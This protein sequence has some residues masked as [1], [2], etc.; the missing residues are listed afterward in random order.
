MSDEKDLIKDAGAELTKPLMDELSSRLKLPFFGAFIFSWLVIN[1]ERVAI[2][3]LSKENVYTRIAKIKEI[4]QIELPVIGNWHSSTFIAPLLYSMLVTAITPFMI[5]AYKKIQKWANKRIIDTQAELDHRYQVS[6]SLEQLKLEKTRHDVSKVKYATDEIIKKNSSLTESYNISLVKIS[7]T[8]GKLSELELTYEKVKSDTEKL[9]L[10]FDGYRA[11]QDKVDQLNKINE[12]HKENLI[13][14]NN[15]INILEMNLVDLQQEVTNSK[16]DANT[17]LNKVTE[18]EA[19]AEI[20][21][22][23]I[24]TVLKY[25]DELLSESEVVVYQ[26]ENISS[27]EDVIYTVLHQIKLWQDILKIRIAKLNTVSTM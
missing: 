27:N 8:E 16:R 22:S 9:K 2:I 23:E 1:W 20:Y 4:P 10:E 21:R 3:L 11:S 6:S 19:N 7:E 12:H 14:A 17:S 13:K 26:L 15:N 24:N 18:L 25:M 5:L